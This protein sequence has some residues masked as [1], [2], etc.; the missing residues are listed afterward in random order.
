MATIS[1]YA[2]HPIDEKN[3]VKHDTCIAVSTPEISPGTQ[4]RV[5]VGDCS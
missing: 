4:L 3:Q 1:R 5:V 2:Y